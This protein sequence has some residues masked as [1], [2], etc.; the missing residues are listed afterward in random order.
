MDR[1]PR[2]PFIIPIELEAMQPAG[3]ELRGPLRQLNL[4]VSTEA[5]TTRGLHVSNTG[6][7]CAAPLPGHRFCNVVVD[8]THPDSPTFG[9]WECVV[10]S[11]G[12]ALYVP[13]GYGNGLQALVA[14]SVYCYLLDGDF[15]PDAE[16]VVNLAD[17][18][19]GLTW[20]QPVVNVSPKDREG[21]SLD[22]YVAQ[23]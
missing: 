16:R 5:G 20:M 15:D 17:P 7:Y 22:A 23:L 14:G 12:T 1:D 18:E 9:R 4:S 21:I 8:L 6:K 11:P 13:P 19:I 3:L 10:L 2:G